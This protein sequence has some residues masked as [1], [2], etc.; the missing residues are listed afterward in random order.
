MLKGAKALNFTQ[1]TLNRGE[2][3]FWSLFDFL[4]S[5]FSISIDGLVYIIILELIG[6]DMTK[7]F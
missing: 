4:R 3:H 7:F 6:Y 2:I 5:C 1:I